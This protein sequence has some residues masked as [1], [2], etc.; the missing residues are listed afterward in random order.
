[1]R[2]V[3]Q[4]NDTTKQKERDSMDAKK[5]EPKKLSTSNTKQE[6]LDA[7]NAVVK[8]LREKDELELKP[9]KKI[10]EK[11]ITE[12]L[13]AAEGVTTDAIATHVASLKTE[14]GKTLSQVSDKLEAEAEKLAKV[15]QAVEIKEKELRDL[16][17]IEKEAQ[18]L[19]ALIQSQAQK[20]EEF[21]TRMVEDREAFESKMAAEKEAIT[22]D[23]DTTRIR[24]AEE[25]KAREAEIKEFE[26]AE[27]KK[28]ER[29]KEEFDYGFKR[30]QKLAKD[31]FED[32]K[33]RLQ[34]EMQTRQAEMD[35]SLSAREKAIAEREQ[36]LADLQSR[37]D[38]FP[39]E[40]E[41][42]VKKSVQETVDRLSVEAKSRDELLKKG[43][44]GEQK[45]LTTR[46]ASLE[47]MVKEQ[48]EQITR[49]TQ[50][51][52]RS[53]EKVE[54]IAVKAV[55]SASASQSSSNLQQMIAEQ[56][57]KQGQEK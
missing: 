42:T 10:E 2:Q 3:F 5:G 16:Y 25:K 13:K 43:F 11:R 35:S 9:E 14:V 8:Q 6:M 50:Q 36:V 15:Q 21:E 17:A 24:W 12:V 30:E 52:E 31:S 32:Q 54:D 45:V 7:Y 55:Q 39:N 48:K 51:L 37:V 38:S 40:M 49:L 46:I 57:R 1:M 33:G 29:E 19:A 20:R 56:S 41:V 44:E 53:Y 34:K 22:R 23:I 28:R 27:K 26:A 4:K 47:Q 18:T